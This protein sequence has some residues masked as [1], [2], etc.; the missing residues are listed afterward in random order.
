MQGSGSAKAVWQ[1]RGTVDAATA[2]HA[3][4]QVIDRCPALNPPR[5]SRAL[6]EQFQRVDHRLDYAPG[7]RDSDEAPGQYQLD[8]VIG[9][10]RLVG[11]RHHRPP[12]TA[13]ASTSASMSS[14]FM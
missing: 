11:V 1:Q 3:K 6:L 12:R 4:T 14:A 8:S 13:V 7:Q 5:W 9:R 2:A 10:R